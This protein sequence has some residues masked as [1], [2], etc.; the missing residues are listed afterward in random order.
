MEHLGAARAEEFDRSE[1]NLTRQRGGR[2]RM[3]RI[4]SQHARST[5]KRQGMPPGSGSRW[6]GDNIRHGKQV[7][8]QLAA[9]CDFLLI[10]IVTDVLPSIPTFNASLSISRIP[11]RSVTRGNP[12]EFLAFEIA[13]CLG[14]SAAAVAPGASLLLSAAHQ[15]ELDQLFHSRTSRKVVNSS[16]LRHYS[17]SFFLSVRCRSNP[18][19]LGW[20][21]ASTVRISASVVISRL[22]IRPVAALGRV[23]KALSGCVVVLM[24]DFRLSLLSQPSYL[25]LSHLQTVSSPCEGL[26]ASE[27]GVALSNFVVPDSTVL[28]GLGPSMLS[29][30]GGVVAYSFPYRG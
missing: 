18:V 14:A 2:S 7:T 20:F 22:G 16:G 19:A 29:Q 28:S 27:S 1:R 6:H 3:E 12:A 23:R 11:T 9:E 26:V 13:F 8:M 21:A 25:L 10:R 30:M 15:A 17:P 5:L 4:Q 24:S